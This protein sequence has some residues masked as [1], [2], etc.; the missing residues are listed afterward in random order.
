M[1]DNLLLDIVRKLKFLR[2][3]IDKILS[4]HSRVLITDFF[5]QVPFRS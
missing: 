2:L 4:E 1:I 3:K 5:G